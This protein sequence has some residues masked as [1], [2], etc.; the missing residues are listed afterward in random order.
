[1]VKERVNWIMEEQKDSH[2]QEDY[3]KLEENEKKVS[4]L[5]KR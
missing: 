3:D 4:T 2:S 1:M 5:Q